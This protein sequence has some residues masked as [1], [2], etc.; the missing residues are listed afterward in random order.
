MR[1]N[2]PSNQFKHKA[3]QII[4]AIVLVFFTFSGAVLVLLLPSAA[5]HQR[6]SLALNGGGF[7]VPKMEMFLFEQSSEKRRMVQAKQ[8]KPKAVAQFLPEFAK[9]A[10][11][12][13]LREEIEFFNQDETFP[14]DNRFHSG[15]TFKKKA[16]ILRKKTESG[17]VLNLKSPS[18]IATPSFYKGTLYLSGGF[19]SKSYYAID[20]KTGNVRWASDLNDDG[21]SS[22]IVTDSMV[23]FNTESCTIFALN[24][25]TGEQIWSKYI[26]DPL[27]THPVSDGKYVYTAYPSISMHTNSQRLEQFQHIKPSHPFAAFDVQTGDVVWRR[28]L[29]G[30]VMT[31]P[32]LN[33]GKV[34]LTTFSGTLYKLRS[35][36]GKIEQAARLKPTSLPTIAGNHIYIT[37]RRKRKGKVYEAVVELNQDLT[38]RRTLAVHPAPYLDF[39]FVKKGKLKRNARKWDASNGFPSAPDIAGWRKASQL[40]GQSNVSSLQNFV[41]ST[42]VYDDKHLFTTMGDTIRCISLASGEE[43]WAYGIEGSL[44]KEGGHLA[45]MPLVSNEY[46]VSVT[47]NGKVLLLDKATG[48]LKESFA[49]KTYVRN[50]PVIVDGKIYVS[51]TTGKMSCIDTQNKA[52]D[53]WPM[54]LKNNSHDFSN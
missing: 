5:D 23:I 15:Q 29:D 20:A 40:I 19:N 18:F 9:M 13:S 27:L 16:N 42:V 37:Q 33:K 28:W 6:S 45:T 51:S 2:Y 43:V 53:G 8:D 54:F 30:D 46:V 32:I 48:D 25:R 31:S 35:S 10:G 50:Q 21:P 24:R 38:I 39:A 1:E 17:Y 14:F 22:A 44:L 11:S 34:Y 4:A 49:T 26:G 12:A 7:A 41:G 3:K 52:L 36:D 47:H